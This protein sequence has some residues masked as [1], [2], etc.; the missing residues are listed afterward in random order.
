MSLKKIYRGVEEQIQEAIAKGEFDN[1]P[2]KGK[3]MDLSGWKKPPAHLRMGDSILKNA[4]IVPVEIQAKKEIAEIRK[5]LASTQDSD[6]R[7]RLTNRRNSLMTTAA[8][9]AANFRSSS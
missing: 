1:L 7:M 2:G 5:I 6:K 9:R 3:P 8:I 4:G